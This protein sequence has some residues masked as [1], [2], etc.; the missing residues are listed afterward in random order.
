[1]PDSAYVCVVEATLHVAGS[2]SLKEKRKVVRSVKDAARR[3]LGAS[4]AEIG[5]HETW[6]HAVILFALVGDA[7]V[8]ARADELE[9]IVESRC[10]TGCRFRRD[11]L[12]L[13]DLREL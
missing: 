3:R 13:Q 8:Q 9:R 4:V 1:M 12:S 10:P 2:G 11:T 5:G 7:G 6:Q